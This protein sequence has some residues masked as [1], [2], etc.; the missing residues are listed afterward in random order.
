[1]LND[2]T[3]PT[4]LSKGYRLPFGTSGENVDAI[5]C[6][7]IN[8]I[9]TLGRMTWDKIRLVL[10]HEFIHAFTS[11]LQ[12][13]RLLPLNSVLCGQQKD[14]WVEY[15]EDV[16]ET[17]AEVYFQV[18]MGSPLTSRVKAYCKRARYPAVY[19]E[20]AELWKKTVAKASEELP[21]SIAMELAI[22]GLC[23]LLTHIVPRQPQTGLV[24]IRAIQDILLP[25]RWR[26]SQD[27]WGTL[28]RRLDKKIATDETLRNQFTLT[29]PAGAHRYIADMVFFVA[30]AISKVELDPD[31]VTAVFPTLLELITQES[32]AVLPVICVSQIDGAPRAEV[33]IT[34]TSYRSR[35]T[36]D[37]VAFVQMKESVE[38]G[39]VCCTTP[40]F[41]VLINRSRQFRLSNSKDRTYKCFETMLGLLPG[42]LKASLQRKTNCPGCLLL[43]REEVFQAGCETIM[44]MTSKYKRAF[45]KAAEGYG[46][47]LKTENMRLI[48]ERWHLLPRPIRCYRF[49]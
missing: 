29:M 43:H 24:I 34:H 16:V 18:S 45:V 6:P 31:T 1:M 9:W 40:I 17:I 41:A 14:P 12:P 19:A 2:L 26:T 46:R 3:I 37:R 20:L 23:M 25:D 30:A 39:E 38:M 33:R 22:R 47:F 42:L 4:M 8:Q 21:K 7:A 28:Y 13:P 32:F 49:L 48:Q 15:F 5:Y 11:S 36:A 44:A 10:S 27:I 35:R